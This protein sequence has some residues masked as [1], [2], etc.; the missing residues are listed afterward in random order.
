[1]ANFL[2]QTSVH[3][4]ARSLDMRIGPM[5]IKAL[6]DRIE[7]IIRESSKKAMIDKR[8]TIL[9]RDIAMEKDLFSQ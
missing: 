6:N 9:A 1:M 8:K 7:E 5:A 2:N 4:Y 3:K